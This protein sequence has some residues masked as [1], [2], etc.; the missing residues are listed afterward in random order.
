M[1]IYPCD[2]SHRFSMKKFHISVTSPFAIMRDIDYFSEAR[3]SASNML[4]F[5]LTL[6]EALQLKFCSI[7]GLLSDVLQGYRGPA[8]LRN[9]KSGDSE[10]EEEYFGVQ[11]IGF[12][13]GVSKKMHFFPILGTLGFAIVRIIEHITRTSFWTYLYFDAATG[14][15]INADEARLIY[16]NN[17]A[18]EKCY[19]KVEKL[20][21]TGRFED[22]Y[23][24]AKIALGLC[25]DGYKHQEKFKR[26]MDEAQSQMR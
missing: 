3:M 16:V 2:E 14:E 17:E 20:M 26:A 8:H 6:P 22:A 15:Q 9:N 25:S 1:F 10:T 7:D 18:A 23:I 13:F 12:W 24:E 21:F 4:S 5:Y 19:I 11:R